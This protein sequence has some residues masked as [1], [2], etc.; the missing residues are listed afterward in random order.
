MVGTS[1]YWN[2]AGSYAI[3]NQSSDTYKYIGKAVRAAGIDDTVVRIRLS[4]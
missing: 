3:N 1:A 4:Q 2:A